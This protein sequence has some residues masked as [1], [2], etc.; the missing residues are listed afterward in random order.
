MRL[1]A[2]SAFIF[3]LMCQLI[4]AQTASKPK[5]AQAFVHDQYVKVDG[6]WEPD[7]PTEK[8]RLVFSV[9]HIECYRTGGR[10]IVGT[11][12]F[13]VTAEATPI[14]G[15]ISVDTG[16]LKVVEWS[17]TEIIMVDDSPECIISQTTIDLTSKTAIGLDIKKPN[18]KGLFDSCKILPDR[19]TYYLRDKVDYHLAHLA[20]KQN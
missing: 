14:M 20:D 18:A 9:I 12:S 13:C 1:V 7:N 16:W 6:V 19:Q 3:V 11:D 2:F 5:L 17:K 10:D 8:N 4:P 15:T